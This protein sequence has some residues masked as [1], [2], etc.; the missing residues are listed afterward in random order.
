M[1]NVK[2]F[3]LVRIITTIAIYSLN[4]R[5][6][7]DILCYVPNTT[8]TISSDVVQIDSGSVE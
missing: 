6:R 2:R 4:I 1:Y 3:F 8:K 5:N 7:K